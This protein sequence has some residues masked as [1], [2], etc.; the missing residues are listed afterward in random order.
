VE[1]DTEHGASQTSTMKPAPTVAELRA[2]T[3]AQAQALIEEARAHGRRRR[4]KTALAMSSLD[5]SIT[6]GRV[7]HQDLPNQCK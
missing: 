2:G 5:V 4:R 6:A 3:S 7:L 1:V